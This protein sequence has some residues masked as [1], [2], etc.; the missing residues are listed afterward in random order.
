MLIPHCHDLVPVRPSRSFNKK[1][2]GNLVLTTEFSEN[3]KG[4]KADVSSVKPSVRAIGGIVDCVW[5]SC[6]KWS[7]AIGE[8]MVTRKQ[9]YDFLA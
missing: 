5:V 6:R 2:V 8:N 1:L 9:E 7:Y 3:I 4:K